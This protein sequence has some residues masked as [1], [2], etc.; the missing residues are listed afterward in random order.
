MVNEE[1]S[2]FKGFF[3][4]YGQNKTNYTMDPGQLNL[5]QQCVN[6]CWPK[7]IFGQKIAISKIQAK[8]STKIAK[9]GGS[10]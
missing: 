8:K 5:S 7:M 9:N 10:P 1:H 6:N 3:G 4:H 2:D